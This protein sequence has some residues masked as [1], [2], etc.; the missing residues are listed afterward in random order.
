MSKDYHINWSAHPNIY[1]NYSQRTF[2]VYFS[3]PDSG[4]NSETGLL[5]LIAGFGGHANSNVYKKMRREFADRY[6]LVTVQCDYFGYEFMQNIKN[7]KTP[8]KSMVSKYFNQN[9]I[10]EIY[11]NSFNVSL[12]LELCSHYDVNF[13]FEEDLNESITNFNDMG[14][15]QALDNITALCYVIQIIR[16]NQLSFNSNKVMVYGHSHGAYLG[17]LCNAFAPNLFT[18]LIDNSSWLLPSYF[19]Q[20]RVLKI[21]NGNI[22]L[23]VCFTYLAASLPFD[24]EI[25]HLPTLYKKVENSSIIDSF[26]GTTDTLISHKDKQQFC[27]EITFSNYHEISPD[28]LDGTM[29]K[30]T[31]HGLGSDHLKLF[32]HVMREKSFAHS[33]NAITIPSFFL[34][35]CKA[36]YS[37]EYDAGIPILKM[38]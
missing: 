12:F 17:Y 1:N 34:D 28:K 29:F 2:D 18:H 16:D 23:S 15:M 9:E 5:L 30:S 32:E 26:H 36:R 31:D 21:N 13:N 8:P 27:K 20:S 33:T 24:K 19:K 25:L 3:E 38:K 10:D 6:N 14:I 35:T 7:L 4:V 22:S 37:F 11:R